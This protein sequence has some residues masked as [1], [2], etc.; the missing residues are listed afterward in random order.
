MG[1]TNHAMG[2]R[3]IKIQ[4]C[5]VE[6]FKRLWQTSRRARRSTWSTIRLLGL[7]LYGERSV[8]TTAAISRHATSNRYPIWEQRMSAR[9]HFREALLLATTIYRGG[10]GQCPVRNRTRGDRCASCVHAR[11]RA[12]RPWPGLRMR[13]WWPRQYRCPSRCRHLPWPERAHRWCHL[14][15]LLPLGLPSACARPVRAWSAV[16]LRHRSRRCQACR[17]P[18]LQLSV[19]PPV[20]ITTF[21]P[22]SLSV[23]S[24][25]RVLAFSGS[26]IAMRPTSRPSAAGA[27]LIWPDGL[28]Q[29]RS[30]GSILARS[31]P[32]ALL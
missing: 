12:N 21:K 14:P 28:G 17:H 27:S 29:R 23:W 20:A 7:M 9:F 18:T 11:W 3:Y 26:E 2:W 22:A 31:R 15:P 13:Y 30:V 25:S 4:R 1:A 8:R 32:E 10:E 6:P 16:W 24:A 5:F 19:H